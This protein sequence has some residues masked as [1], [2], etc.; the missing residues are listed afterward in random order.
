LLKKKKKTTQQ[1]LSFSDLSSSNKQQTTESY[2]EERATDVYRQRER[3]REEKEGVLEAC[4]EA[5]A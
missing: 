4:Q 2:A 1:R 3:A 5:V